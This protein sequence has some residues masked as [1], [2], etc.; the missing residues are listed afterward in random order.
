M[1]AENGQIDWQGTEEWAREATI[2]QLLGALDDILATLDSADALDR[3]DGGTRG[4]VYRDECSVYR[5]ILAE[6]RY[7]ELVA[8]LKNA[9]KATSAARLVA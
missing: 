9:T 6:E 5:R 8:T 7:P 4:G 1:K 2:P 3:E